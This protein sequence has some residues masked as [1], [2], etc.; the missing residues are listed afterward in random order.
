MVLAGE[1]QYYGDSPGDAVEQII[2]RNRRYGCMDGEQLKNEL[3]YV[4]ELTCDY[5]GRDILQDAKGILAAVGIASIV[6]VPGVPGAYPYEEEPS[7]IL[8][9]CKKCRW[10]NEKSKQRPGD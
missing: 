9:E 3:Q 2:A 6:Y 5:C 10:K 7:A 4:T 8:I 1:L